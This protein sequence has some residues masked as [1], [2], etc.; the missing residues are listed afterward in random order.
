MFLLVVLNY[1]DAAGARTGPQW[2]TQP[3]NGV[4]S[5]LLDFT[6]LIHLLF[7][8]FGQQEWLARAQHIAA[9]ALASRA[10]R[11][12]R[13]KLVHPVIKMHHVSSR[14]IK[15]DEAIL[16]RKD[17]IDCLVSELEQ[18]IKISCR[19]NALDYFSDNLAFHFRAL[20]LGNVQHNA[21]P[22][23]FTG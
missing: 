7:K 18:L 8:F 6:S 9:K 20:V 3:R 11:R 12:G 23:A 22:G 19:D 16:C 17:F 5:T 2:D 13:I 21:L 14:V 10:R 4:G 15:S 1:Q